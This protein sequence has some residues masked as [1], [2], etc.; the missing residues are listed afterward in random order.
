MAPAKKKKTAVKNTK[1]TKKQ[2][3]APA[4]ETV[5]EEILP[6]L[7]I[8]NQIMPAILVLVAVY[9]VI[10]YLLNS[11]TGIF[12]LWLKN[13]L[14]GLFSYGAWAVPVLLVVRAFLWK[15]DAD[16]K[17]LGAKIAFSVLF[18]LGISTLVDVFSSFIGL[19]AESFSVKELFVSGMALK[20]GGLIG[21]AFRFLLSPV[22]TTGTLIITFA[23]VFVCG[24]FML[25]ITPYMIWIRIMYSIKKNREAM[26]ER[27]MEY[28][29]KQS[30]RN[31]VR[32]QTVL[33]K[34]PARETENNDNKEDTSEPIDIDIFNQVM[35]EQNDDYDDKEDGDATTIDENYAS[36]FVTSVFPEKPIKT[37]KSSQYPH[38]VDL[39]DIFGEDGH[40]EIDEL[41]DEKLE[42]SRGEELTSAELTVERRNV[43]TIEKKEEPVPAHVEYKFPPITLLKKD[44]SIKN[45][46]TTEE[47]RATATKL[48]E[49]LKSYK[50][51]TRLVSISRGPS[52]TRYELSPE[53]GTKVNSIVNR[54]DDIS[55]HL[56]T[57]GVRIVAPI[58]GMEAVGVEVPNK[59]VSLVYIR[60]LLENEEFKKHPSKIHVALGMDVTGRP[61]F[62]DIAK[63][64]HLLIAGATGMGK[65]V[66]INSTIIS[67]LYKATPDEVKL[68][69]IDPKQVEFTMYDGIPHLLV[70]V[71][72]DP[73][74]AA[75]TLHWAVT[76][77]ERR[78][79]LINGA[80][81]RNIHGYNEKMKDD[82]DAEYMPQIV[83]I[84]DELADLMLT[85][86]NDVD[87][88]IR[89]L[90]AK[91][92]AAG[93][94]LILGTQRPSVDVIT[95]TIKSNI[96]YRIAFTTTSYVDSRTILDVAG[97]EKLIGKGD[98][99]YAATGK[100]PIR[101]QGSFVSDEEVCEITDFV[102]KNCGGANYNA[103]VVESIEREAE[104]CGN[105][106]ST[107]LGDGELDNNSGDPLLKAAIEIAVDAGKIS[108][109]LLQRKLSIG[110]GRAAKIIDIMEERGIV[111]AQDGQKPR[112][113]LWTKQQYMESI[114]KGSSY[115]E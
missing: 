82:P 75:G 25:G 42:E 106:K 36:P 101:V 48:V 39:D 113:T 67:I 59:N 103:Q 55:L 90:S 79:E 28:A 7:R 62:M 20:G 9:I 73:K 105:K 56:A 95:G 14:Y 87:E 37:K 110:F 112:T 10:C 108:T 104:L 107:S 91:A 66:C 3:K 100:S 13:F 64:P 43:G 38:A 8:I 46:D 4:K 60:E 32:E 88:S 23:L 11:S 85:A 63:M 81:V 111:S 15:D 50:I 31:R 74:K 97:A 49:T 35:D 22:G 68:I 16:N 69:L 52:I 84:I 98:M 34:K 115:E 6:S 5:K 99:L 72:T 33:T 58:P 30:E 70:P 61:I 65:S 21:G 86:S 71:V 29:E 78:Y 89:R 93:I 17:C 96:P 18:I 77:M 26:R 92:R 27:E 114:V 83:I 41:F 12:G 54:I 94:H 40:S 24:F 45:Q 57:T 1:I 19:S 53:V 109:S 102:K 51:N 2:A 76:E 47:L 44:L 80:S